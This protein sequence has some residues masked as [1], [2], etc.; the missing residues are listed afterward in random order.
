[1]AMKRHGELALDT[2]LDK[3]DGMTRESYAQ[4]DDAVANE[5][6]CGYGEYVLVHAVGQDGE[7][8]LVSMVKGQVLESVRL[9]EASMKIRSTGPRTPAMRGIFADNSS[10]LQVGKARMNYGKANKHFPH[11][12]PIVP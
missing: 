4:Y 6:D 7:N 10:N 1:M 2:L 11:R 9:M 12:L 5:T 3:A 8:L